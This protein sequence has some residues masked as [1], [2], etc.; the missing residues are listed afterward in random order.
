MD[1]AIR[2]AQLIFRKIKGTISPSEEEELDAWVNASP[3]NQAFMR[4]EIQPE[5]IAEHLMIVADMDLEEL[6]QKVWSRIRQS[7]MLSR[8]RR[9]MRLYGGSGILVVVFAGALLLSYFKT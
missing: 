4:T 3:E 5:S 2:I 9:R 6:D 1:D 7:R 8:R